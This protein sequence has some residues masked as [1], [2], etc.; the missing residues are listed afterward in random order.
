MRM[1][2]L[3]LPEA[4]IPELAATNR[5]EAIREM[6]NSLG[7]CVGFD[8][9][10]LAD[11]A[12]AI[13][14]RE[15]QG[16]TAFGKGVALPHARHPAARR[17]IAAIARSSRGIDFAALDREPVYLVILLVSP[18]DKTDEHLV[19]MELLFR[20][21]QVDNL[22]RFLL[23]AETKEEMWD[24]V[25]EADTIAKDNARVGVTSGL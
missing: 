6:V 7:A 2:D 24:L 19:A 17:T 20:V 21:V 3:V 18:P 14:L 25:I 13:T 9:A 10:T 22:R 5:N 8:E 15:N 4:L 23:R 16:T 1:A 12:H 11:V